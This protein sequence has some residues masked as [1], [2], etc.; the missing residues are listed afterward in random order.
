MQNSAC[1][2]ELCGPAIFALIFVP[3]F[4]VTQAAL[5]VWREILNLL[6]GKIED[7][8]ITVAT[9]AN[10]IRRNQELLAVQPAT[11]VDN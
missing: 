5:V 4:I 9:R 3:A 2:L 7:K 8:L 10:T 6:F 11:G 1:L